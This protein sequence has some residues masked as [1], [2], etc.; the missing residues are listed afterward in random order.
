MEQP[1]LEIT[2]SLDLQRKRPTLK[3]LK[4]VNADEFLHDLNMEKLPKDEGIY[5]I[6][7]K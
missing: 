4:I 7:F 5:P 1:E 6:N 3:P 2:D